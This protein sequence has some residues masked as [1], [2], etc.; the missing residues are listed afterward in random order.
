MSTFICEKC[1][2]IDNTAMKNNAWMA[3]YNKECESNNEEYLAEYKDSYYNTHL[4]CA[5]CCKNIEYADGSGYINTTGWHNKFEKIH[6]NSIG[7]E[8]CLEIEKENL[9]SMINA[10]DYFKNIGE[11]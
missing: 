6:W 3:L 4:C 10:T 7:K 8:K 9:G 11:L 2:C 5:E 1:G